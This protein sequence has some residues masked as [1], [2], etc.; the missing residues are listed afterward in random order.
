MDIKKRASLAVAGGVLCAALGSI[1]GGIV[2]VI[3]RTTQRNG[4]NV[5]QALT[6][7]PV[8]VMFAAIPAAPFGFLVGSVGSWWLS[9]RVDR[10]VSRR[11]LYFASA[12]MG[13]V[14]GATFPLIMS[15][16][17][18]GPFNNLVS[19]LP[20]S[21]GVGTVCGLTLSVYLRKRLILPS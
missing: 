9:A 19:A 20:I 8:A 3:F 16:L 7:L 15:I 10:G 14:L 13:A 12:G 11:R 4:E 1:L 6:F 5:A 18:W 17:G 21:I 2:V